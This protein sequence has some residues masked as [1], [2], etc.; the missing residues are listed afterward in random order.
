MQSHD[1]TNKNC[2]EFGPNL[3]EEIPSSGGDFNLNSVL[4]SPVIAIKLNQI[5]TKHKES[6]LTTI[7]L[8]NS[9]Q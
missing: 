7:I 1:E 4:D 3:T 5:S 8:K 6:L 9:V 2:E